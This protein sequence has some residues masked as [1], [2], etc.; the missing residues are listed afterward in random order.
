MIK[1]KQPRILNTKRLSKTASGIITL[2]DL[3]KKL[4]REI[5]ALHK[6]YKRLKISTDVRDIAKFKRVKAVLKRYLA[7]EREIGKILNKK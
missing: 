4:P 6:E 5:V 2:V 7:I 3:Q 1:A